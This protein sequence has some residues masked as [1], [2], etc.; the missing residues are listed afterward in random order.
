MEDRCLFD[1]DCTYESNSDGIFFLAQVD[2]WIDTNVLLGFRYQSDFICAV[3]LNRPTVLD[4]SV[5]TEDEGC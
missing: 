1:C 5:H 4:K 2:R 3:P